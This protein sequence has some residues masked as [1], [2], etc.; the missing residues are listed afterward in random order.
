MFGTGV[1]L[2]GVQN[3]LHRLSRGEVGLIMWSHLAVHPSGRTKKYQAGVYDDT[4]GDLHIVP[5]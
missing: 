3:R 5:V 1:S 2:S 4:M